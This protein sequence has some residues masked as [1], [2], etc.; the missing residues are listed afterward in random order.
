MNERITAIRYQGGTVVDIPPMLGFTLAQVM[1]VR[2][3]MPLYQV[4]DK[5]PLAW[6][7]NVT[8]LAGKALDAAQDGMKGS[9]PT[10]ISYTSKNGIDLHA[11]HELFIQIAG[12]AIAAAEATDRLI[13]N[14]EGK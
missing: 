1:K 5:N 13:S 8:S 3:T 2:S 10:Y 9:G 4:A 12:M 7:V 11:I 6:A 14:T